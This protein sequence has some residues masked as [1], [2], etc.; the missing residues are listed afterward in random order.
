MTTE[1]QYIN[2]ATKLGYEDPFTND[3]VEIL[4]FSLGGKKYRRF[5]VGF[6]Q[7]PH[8]II[9]NNNVRQQEIDETYCR[10][11]L[12]PK[13]QRSGLRC[14]I[15]VV[16]S[17]QSYNIDSGHHRRYSHEEIY[18]I[19]VPMPCFVLSP[20]VCEVLPNGQYGPRQHGAYLR[21]I[22]LIRSNPPRLN[23]A[24]TMKD[25]EHHLKDLRRSDPTFGGIIASGEFPSRDVFNAVMDEVYPDDFG[26]KGTRTKIYNNLTKGNTVS[27]NK[28]VS[29]SDV[30]NDLVQ[31]GY[32]TG[33]TKTKAGKTKRE[34]FLD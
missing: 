23:K 10:E 5:I 15:F 7:F 29:F 31:F 21:K 33:V 9:F 28:S 22:S 1:Q 20:Y 30:T 32:D 14:P 12:I 27:K 25:A 26:F 4:H 18:G 13:I 34:K 11:E 16:Q 17:G 6:D 3:Q 24:Y 19:N 8:N 2:A